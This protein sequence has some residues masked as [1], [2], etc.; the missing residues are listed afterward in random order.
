MPLY[1]FVVGRCCAM[2]TWRV[3]HNAT[4]LYHS[5][6]GPSCT[7]AYMLPFISCRLPPSASS[8][9]MY[10]RADARL[11]HCAVYATI[12]LQ[13]RHLP[14]ADIPRTPHPTPHPLPHPTPTFTPPHPPAPTPPAHPHPT[15]TPTPPPPHFTPCNTFTH[16]HL[17][18]TLPY[19]YC[20]D[21]AIRCTLVLGGCLTTTCLT[22][23]LN[24]V[25][26][27]VWTFCHDVNIPST[28][29]GWPAS[30]PP[31]AP[32]TYT[33]PPCRMPCHAYPYHPYPPHYCNTY[34]SSWRLWLRFPRC[35]TRTATGR[36]H[37]TAS[38]VRRR[39][40]LPSASHGIR[41]W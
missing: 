23:F 33:L 38:L 16:H 10:R 39:L 9:A 34:R 22:T 29:G 24:T 1:T 35:R 18:Y 31:A 32:T 37:T 28:V 27:R 5:P 6:G 25:M 13:P 7:P 4:R 14:A 41:R 17:T 40:T 2:P 21:H 8:R 19:Y 36:H 3:Y 26:G 11:P 30:R 20:W 12:L 15:P